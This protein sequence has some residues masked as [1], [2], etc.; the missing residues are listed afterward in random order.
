MLLTFT[1]TL[2]SYFVEG[3]VVFVGKRKTFSKRVSLSS[4]L[5]PS[6]R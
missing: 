2:Y 3:N 4:H 1:Q 6:Y 5:A